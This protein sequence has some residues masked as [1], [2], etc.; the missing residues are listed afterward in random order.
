MT[1]RLVEV[2]VGS[3]EEA[4]GSVEVTVGSVKVAVGS[5]DTVETDWAL[6]DQRLAII[7]QNLN[8][9]ACYNR[10]GDWRF[11]AGHDQTLALEEELEEKLCPAAAYW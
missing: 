5:V 7:W 10:E 11:Y 4:V 1:V 2:T 6:S 9:M 8:Y 3:V